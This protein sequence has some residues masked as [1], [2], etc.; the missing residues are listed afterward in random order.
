MLDKLGGAADHDR[1][2]IDRIK[3]ILSRPEAAQEAK[4]E[5]E[6][7]S[8][9]FIQLHL[10]KKCAKYQMYFGDYNTQMF[11]KLCETM[12]YK[13][14][15]H[16]STIFDKED[17]A[18]TFYFILK[19]TVHL[20][21]TSSTGE[22]KISKI[23]NENQ[24]FG[25]L[26]GTEILKQVPLRNA[27]AKSEN[28]TILLAIDTLAYVTIRKERILSA[29]EQKVDYLI[30]NIPGMRSAKREA[31][32]ELETLFTTEIMTKGFRIHTQDKINE[33]LYF[34]ISG[35]C[36]IL[37]NYN[38]NKSLKQKFD[39]CDESLPSLIVIGTLTKGDCIGQSSS[40]QR[41]V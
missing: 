38:L 40:I 18:S 5:S 13:E 21:E 30:Q 32:E 15:E 20:Y 1:M 26:K 27:T 4:D 22:D 17:L 24:V 8:Y 28:S 23:F 31:I 19:G 7:I 36:K 10:E 11:E 14:Y 34:I 16:D 9:K 2:R 29:A 37:Y 41:Q 6:K 35:E 3:S 39:N 33:H 25:L 12:T